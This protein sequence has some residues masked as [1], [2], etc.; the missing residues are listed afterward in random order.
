MRRFPVI[1]FLFMSVLAYSQK[2]D[3][4]NPFFTVRG[5]VGIPRST[6]SMM[7]RQSFT[8]IYE[9]N[10]A[11]VVRP[12]KNFVVGLG[13]QNALFKNVKSIGVIQY[14]QGGKTIALS[15]YNTQIIEHGG[16]FK[17]GY[18]Q[19]VTPTS[20]LN[21]S[22]NSGL[23]FCQYTGVVPDTSI[24]NR[25]YG[26]TKFFAPYTQPEISMH[27]IAG[28]EQL[29]SFSMMLSYTT[30]F[31]KFDPKAPRFNGLPDPPI[32]TKGNRY[33]MNW[34]NIGLGFNVL[35]KGKAK[36]TPAEG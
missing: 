31:Y 2:I 32:Y 30:L 3:K 14:S 9:V 18:D 17:M 1:L 27:F 4:Q 19:F 36:G 22:I 13:Y 16:F 15:N 34:I 11:A 10:L 8:G 21:Y 20:Y 12:G 28:E 5:N 7:F 24:A 6:G 26:E 25:P 33:F 29:L 23:M 35:I